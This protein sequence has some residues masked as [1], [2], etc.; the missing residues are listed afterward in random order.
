MGSISQS[1]KWL[2]TGASQGLGLAMAM[3]ALKAGH[4]V[5]AGARNPSNA[6]SDHPEM[7]AAGGKWLQLDVSRP[8]AQAAVSKAIEEA[9]GI[10]VVVNNAGVYPPGSIEDVTYEHPIYLKVH[11]TNTPSEKRRCN[12]PCP[13]T[14]SGLF[15]CSK[16]HCQHCELKILA[17]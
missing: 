16:E 9:G 1:K 15:V 14:S 17:R 13:R 6:A 7:E 3:S 10:D 2:I 8:E 5:L 11:I 12:K 4:K